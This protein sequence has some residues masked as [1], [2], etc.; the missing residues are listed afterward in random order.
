M[1]IKRLLTDSLTMIIISPKKRHGENGEIKL[2]LFNQ[3]YIC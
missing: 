2:V 3:F 1:K